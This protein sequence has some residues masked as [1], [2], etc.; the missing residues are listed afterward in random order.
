MAR[1]I[2]TLDFETQ[3]IGDRPGG[4]PPE[5]V[6]VALLPDN[7]NAAYLAWGHPTGNNCDRDAAVQTILRVSAGHDTI[8]CHNAPFDIAVMEERL[9]LVWRKRIDDT[10][11]TAFMADP[12]A[13]SLSLKPLAQRHLGMAPSERDEVRDWLIDHGV[14]R[15]GA[16]RAWGAHIA[17]APGD[18]VG[19]YAIGDVV[20]TRALFDKLQPAVAAPAYEREMRIARATIDM[21]RAGI[22]VDT[23]RLGEDTERFTRLHERMEDWIRA[24]LR[25]PG[26]ELSKPDQLAAAIESRYGITLPLT[27]TGKQ[28]TDRATLTSIIPDRQM[29]AALTWESAVSYNLSTYMRPFLAQAQA[30]NGR[31]HAQWNAVRGANERK[32]G[33]GARTGRFSSSPNLQNL[34][35]EDGE[36]RLKKRLIELFACEWAL[37]S[38]RSYIVAPPGQHIIGRDYSQI[39]LRIAAHYE[40]GAIAQMY[41]DKPDADLHRWVVDRVRELYGMELERRIAKNVGFG[42]LYGAG[43]RAIAAQAGIPYDDAVRFKGIYLTALPSLRELM[44]EVQDLG[45]Y[46]D[47]ITTLGGRRYRAEPKRII[48]GEWR[49]FEYKLLNY[50][51]QGSAADLMKEALLCAIDDGLDVRMTV[52]DEIVAYS[53]DPAVDL[54]RLES[55]MLGNDLARAL[56]VP[57]L[58]SGYVG[59]DWANTKEV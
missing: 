52:H 34:K 43:G 42:I 22:L 36:E 55:A 15:R 23:E 18:V 2:L 3:A 12:Y 1:R 6:G 14:V 44:N 26:L 35:T 21:E 37:P 40:E 49:T 10:L 27:D 33:G 13:P 45:R 29:L 19:P 24:N 17:Q 54:G 8:L 30:N 5:P 4:W 50:L 51:I 57:V 46:G 31:V 11:V 47:F 39:E 25:A 20:R 48:D 7:S 28:R 58:T 16:T 41:R 32:G 38:I 59:R 9:G 53:S 56:S